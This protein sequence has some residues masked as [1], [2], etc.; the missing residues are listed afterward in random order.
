MLEWYFGDI[1]KLRQSSTSKCKFWF[2]MVKMVADSCQLIY[3]FFQN[4]IQRNYGTWLFQPSYVCG[5]CQCLLGQVFFYPRYSMYGIFTYIYPKNHPNVGKYT[6]HGVSGY[7]IL[8]FSTIFRHSQTSN[9]AQGPRHR[10]KL[11]LLG[12]LSGRAVTTLLLFVHL[13]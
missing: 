1:S 9:H 12:D 5:I 8:L 7:E 4:G 3:A 6:I 2:V 11:G 10:C 13:R